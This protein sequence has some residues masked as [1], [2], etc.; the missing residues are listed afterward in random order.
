MRQRHQLML[1]YR[2]EL[3]RA[4]EQ[5]GARD[6]E[7]V[8][9]ATEQWDATVVARLGE[10]DARVLGDVVEALRRLDA[11]TYGECLTCGEEIGDARLDAL[12]TATVCIECANEARR[13]RVDVTHPAHAAR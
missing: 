8:E 4:D 10:T 11:G 1:R 3:D 6:A 9:R 5:L 7:M 12:P 2:D 13:T